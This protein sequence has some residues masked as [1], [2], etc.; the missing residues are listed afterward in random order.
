MNTTLLLAVC[1]TL[2]A[3]AV[4]QDVSIF[5]VPVRPSDM[6]DPA[7]L[8]GRIKA[9]IDKGCGVLSVNPWEQWTDIARCRKQAKA[10]TARQMQR[11]REL[12]G[13]GFE[14]AFRGR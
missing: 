5:V 8:N 4:A 6:K 14:L 11:V 1:L 3:P 2:A 13:E 12:K 7:A 9:A 10:D